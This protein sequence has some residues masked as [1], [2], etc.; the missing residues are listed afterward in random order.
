MYSYYLVVYS[1]HGLEILA[2]PCNNFGG[3]EPGSH[4][5]IMSYVRHNKHASFPI[6]GKVECDNHAQTHPLFAF[7]K[8]KVI[9][10]V[11]GPGLIWNFAKFL[12]DEN[13]VPIKRYLPIQAPQSFEEDI[14]H[15]LGLSS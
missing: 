10:K 14:K 12:C 4:E 7:L 13:G 5:E 6:F 1:I 15:V 9:H 2:F 11:F 8:N 3:Q